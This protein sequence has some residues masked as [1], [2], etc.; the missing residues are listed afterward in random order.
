MVEVTIKD[1][2]Y[3]VEVWYLGIGFGQKVVG[4]SSIKI[5]LVWM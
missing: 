4:H 2:T 5:N 3:L 1:C